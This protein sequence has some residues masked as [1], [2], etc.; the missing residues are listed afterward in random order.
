MP[1]PVIA[2]KDA[3]DF[4]QDGLCRVKKAGGCIYVCRGAYRWKRWLLIG[5]SRHIS[6]VLVAMVDIKRIDGSHAS[7]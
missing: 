5:Y 7:I 6:F 3:Y 1:S 4:M 2:F